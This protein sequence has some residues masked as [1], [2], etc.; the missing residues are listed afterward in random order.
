MLRSHGVACA[1]GG[2][3][4]QM[5]T[6]PGA[7]TESDL[8]PSSL[9]KSSSKECPRILPRCPCFRWPCASDRT[10]Q[11]HE[12]VAVPW[13]EVSWLRLGGFRTT[14]DLGAEGGGG[15]FQIGSS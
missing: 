6:E 9:Q 13:Q 3:K 4:G 12:A 7:W 5:R 2:L 11:S 10:M 8:Y 1:G 15:M 14:S